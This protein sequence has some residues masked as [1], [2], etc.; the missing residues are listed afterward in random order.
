M[1]D[2]DRLRW[3]LRDLEARRQAHLDNA[4]HWRAE[5]RAVAQQRDNPPTPQHAYE[6]QRRTDARVAELTRSAERSR[7]EAEKTLVEIRGLE[8]EIRSRSGSGR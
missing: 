6:H 4:D 7:L 1:S 3:Q 8:A 2:I 5:A